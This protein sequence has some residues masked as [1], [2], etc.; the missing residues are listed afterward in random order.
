MHLEAKEMALMT[1]QAADEKK[2]SN[3]LIMDMQDVT[4]ITDY[5]VI[6]SGNSSTQ[7][8]AIV[9]HIE[10]KMEETCLRVHHR[11]GYR[12]AKWVLMDY[13]EIIVH[14]FQNEDRAFYDLERLWADAPAFTLEELS[15]ALT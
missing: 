3:I 15:E 2:A 9:D 14:V 11:E 8:Q 12:E 7:V 5:F 4:I 10:E 13:G 6:C 1:A